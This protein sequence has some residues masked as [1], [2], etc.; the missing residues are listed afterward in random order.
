[1]AS[2]GFWVKHHFKRLFKPENAARLNSKADGPLTTLAGLPPELILSIIALLTLPDIICFS[3]CNHRLLQLCQGH[4]KRLSPSPIAREDKLSILTRLERDQPEYFTCEVC[5]LLHKFDG[6]HSLGLDDLHPKKTYHLPC[7]RIGNHVRHGRVNISELL[8]P[9]GDILRAHYSPSY[10]PSHLSFLH[11]KLAMRK[12][13]NASLPGIATDSLSWTQVCQTGAKSGQ[14]G[15]IS[16][17]SREA[18]ICPEHPS[19]YVRLQ[20]IVLFNTW[21]ELQSILDIHGF[22]YTLGGYNI[23]KLFMGNPLEICSHL[24]LGHIHEAVDHLLD[25]HKPLSAALCRI[26]MTDYQ[27]E[28]AKVYSKSALIITRWINLGLGL[29]QQDL[30]WKAHALP[31]GLTSSGSLD[32]Y[33]FSPRS[34]F[35]HAAS[36][37]FENEFSPRSCFEHAA[38]QSLE[39]LRT[40]N[41]SYLH[42]QQYKYVMSFKGRSNRSLWF[43][44]Y[45]EPPN[46]RGEG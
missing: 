31:Y 22:G 19:L 6:L 41:L 15:I 7:I 9:K 34:S 27:I 17:F 1:M 42:D 25:S 5:N 20:D 13:F 37:S 4:I 8:K 12:F 24:G 11:I 32:D 40:R 26:C 3:L 35:E 45:K 46:T 38:S 14:P 2:L 23:V 18:E 10:S 36:Q 44:S 29:S 21:N 30:L 33:E 39:D 16:L 28:L 43:C